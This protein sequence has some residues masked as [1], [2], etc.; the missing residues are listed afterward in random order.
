MTAADPSLMAG[1]IAVATLVAFDLTVSRILCRIPPLQKALE[2]SPTV[3]VS[4]GRI[5]WPNMKKEKITE[6]DLLQS[7]REG[8][9][10]DVK[11][12]RLAVLEVDG[13]ISVI[14]K[15]KG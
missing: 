4:Q 8:G 13:N 15:E 10:I 1:L 2:G 3:L 11:D 5:L 7:C 6:E 9:L 12:V 14:P